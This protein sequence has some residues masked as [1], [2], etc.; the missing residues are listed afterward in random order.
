MGAQRWSQPQRHAAAGG[1]DTGAWHT[2]APLPRTLSHSLLLQE[3]KRGAH[4]YMQFILIQETEQV[5]YMDRGDEQERS[6]SMRNFLDENF[7]I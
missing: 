2:H 1:C 3:D 5:R 4:A 7:V 6:C